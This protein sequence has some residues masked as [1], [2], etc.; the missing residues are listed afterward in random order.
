MSTLA[1]SV[2]TAI[3]AAILAAV[4]TYVT[5]RR[6]LQ[7]QFDAHLRELRIGAYQDLWKRLKVLAKYGR[8]QELDR[9]QVQALGGDLSKWYFEIGGMFLS[10]PTRDDYFALQDAIERMLAMDSSG[11]LSREEDDFLRLLSSRLRTGMTRDVGTRKTFIFRGDVPLVELRRGASGA[12]RI[13]LRRACL[14]RGA[15]WR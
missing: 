5:T 12:S 15:L 9:D 4:G 13:W 2:I 8:T 1:A 3:V 6:N 11:A 7:M 10:K 14:G